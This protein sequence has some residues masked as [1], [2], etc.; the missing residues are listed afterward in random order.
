MLIKFSCFKIADVRIPTAF[1]S[2]HMEHVHSQQQQSIQLP[3]ASGSIVRG[4]GLGHVGFRRVFYVQDDLLH[5]DRNG[6]RRSFDIF[7][8]SG[9]QRTIPSLSSWMGK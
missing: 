1:V 8:V 4:E 2:V 5:C 6:F 9:S 3:A 7:Q